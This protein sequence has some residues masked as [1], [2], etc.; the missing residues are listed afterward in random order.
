MARLA[1]FPGGVES[2]IEH[3]PSMIHASIPAAERRKAGLADG[4]LRLGVGIEDKEDLR[5]DLEQAFAA[6]FR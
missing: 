3:P 6:T 1:R 5:V 4:L 2:L